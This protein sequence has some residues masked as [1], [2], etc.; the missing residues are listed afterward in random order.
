M[1]IK[2]V[3]FL[4]L[5]VAIAA[6]TF[7]SCG[8]DNGDDPTPV[9]GI[10]LDKTTLSL[11]VGETGNLT[12]TLTPQGATGTVT[13]T[14][15]NTAIAT[16]ADGVVTGVSVGTTTVT[17]TCEG[18][19]G[20]CAI[21]VTGTTVNPSESLQGS[22]YYI[23]SLDGVSATSIQS[24]IVADLRPDDVTKFLY[25][26]DETYNAGTSVGPNF[27]GHVEGWTSL[28]VGSVGWSGAGLNVTDLSLLNSMYDITANPNDYYL[29]IAIKSRDNATHMIGFDGQSTGRIVLGNI[30]FVDNGVTYQP[31]TNFT[32]DGEWQEIEIPVSTLVANGL[33]F[34]NN[35]TAD[36]NALWVLSGGVAGTTLD[37]D[38]V[39]FYKK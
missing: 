10:I 20:T 34:S 14:S 38:A 36:K 15:A 12:A 27:Y 30:A 7:S 19:T 31:T 9:T 2:N 3:F 33:L 32:R 13:W 4:A 37:L 24:K 8:G 35:N 21:T 29:H 5:S 17:A 1:K 39:F 16:V 25:I 28:V 22:N 6:V 11:G 23:F 18:F 26:W